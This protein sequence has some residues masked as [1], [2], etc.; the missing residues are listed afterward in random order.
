MALTDGVWDQV[1]IP[2]PQVRNPRTTFMGR[3]EKQLYILRS[4]EGLRQNDHQVLLQN[5]V[6]CWIWSRVLSWDL[7]L[8]ASGVINIISAHAFPHN[9]HIHPSVDNSLWESIP[10]ATLSF[11]FKKE[12]HRTDFTPK[13]PDTQ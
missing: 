7:L 12:I 2:E 9:L 6:T 3:Q 13:Q 4:R 11:D 1:E 10:L 8:W 5:E